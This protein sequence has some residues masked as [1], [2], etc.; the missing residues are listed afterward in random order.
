MLVQPRPLLSAANTMNGACVDAV[1]DSNLGLRSRV[2]ADGANLILGQFGV[3]LRL[4]AQH[5]LAFLGFNHVVGLRSVAQMSDLD[6]RPVVTRVQDKRLLGRWRPEVMSGHDSV[7]LQATELSIPQFVEVTD[8][9]QAL[10]FTLCASHYG[11]EV[12]DAVPPSTHVTNI[13]DE[14]Q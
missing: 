4:A 1:F 5:A 8:V 12:T 11:V 14:G 3:R 13:P 9:D 10:A 6:T 2:V 7:N